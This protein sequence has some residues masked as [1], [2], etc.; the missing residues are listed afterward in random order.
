MSEPE[1]PLNTLMKR[2]Y[3]INRQSKL[4]I[5]DKD[6]LFTGFRKAAAY[7]DKNGD[8]TE[9]DYADAIKSLLINTGR[10]TKITSIQRTQ[11]M[12]DKFGGLGTGKDIFEIKTES[13]KGQRTQYF[14]LD[15]ENKSWSRQ[16]I[17][18]VMRNSGINFYMGNANYTLGYGKLVHD[19]INEWN[20]AD[21]KF[22]NKIEP[23][24]FKDFL[25]RL[26][27]HEYSGKSNAKFY[28]EK[29]TEVYADM[30]PAEF[31]E[32]TESIGEGRARHWKQSFLD[33]HPEVARKYQQYEEYNLFQS[34][35]EGAWFK[36]RCCDF[37]N[38]YL[39]TTY[40]IVQQQQYNASIEKETHAKSWEDKKHVNKA[41][42]KIMQSS[43]LNKFFSGLE[44]DNDV[45]L[46]KFSDFEREMG[47]LINKLPSGKQSPML[48][49]RKL[50]N[51]KASGLYVP[52]L[53]TLVVDFRQPGE[54]YANQPENGT[55]EKAGYSSFI[56]EYGHYLDFQ[57]HPEQ[58]PLSLQERFAPILNDYQKNLATKLKGDAKLGYY[59][60]PTEVFARA[61]ELY[62]HDAGLEGNLIGK[63]Y[64]YSLDHGSPEYTAFT[65][66]NRKQLTDYFDNMKEFKGLRQALNF[67]SSREPQKSFDFSASARHRDQSLQSL[68][69]LQKY[70]FEMLHKWTK[71]P[72]TMERLI[73]VTGKT[74]GINNVNRVL[75]Y[76]LWQDKMPSQL[77]TVKQL[78]DQGLG[79]NSFKDLKYMYGYVPTSN[80]KWQTGK[81]FSADELKE[82][83]W[84][85]LNKYSRVVKAVPKE[86]NEHLIM[87]PKMAEDFLQKIIPDHNKDSVAKLE[88]K[89][90]RWILQKRSSLGGNT[91]VKAFRFSNDDLV[92]IKQAKLDQNGMAN[93]Y[94][95][96]A[97]QAK[98]CEKGLV[99][100]L[101]RQQTRKPIQEIAAMHQSKGRER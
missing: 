13:S 60:T 49:L 56:H 84:Q 27:S 22:H 28:F 41:T 44:L 43:S 47:R 11:T 24:D 57:L 14:L 71:T 75:A 15:P 23:E 30:T 4:S 99:R 1:N 77:V 79:I 20:R 63:D 80:H 65:K 86:D 101:N 10:E 98:R 33:H 59:S 29:S 21:P 88:N 83:A 64:E 50:G 95:H 48:R 66:D 37:I 6:T 70:S 100:Q 81:L 78:E 46:A 54:I 92:T 82:K 26:T 76:D 17:R 32:N 73:N 58:T 85:D 52:N 40:N 97:D 90:S 16:S 61:F 8:W 45:D 96:A 31:M 9:Q 67:D 25:Y 94:L 12:N 55:K 42:Q 7:V 69:H 3:G 18:Y 74:L 19:V 93:L 72:E 35:H 2:K 5:T 91:E 89:I 51:H 68:D 39:T 53:N 38:Q 87:Q 34:Q 36:N 62:A